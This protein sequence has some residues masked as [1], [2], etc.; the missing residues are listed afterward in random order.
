[1]ERREKKRHKLQKTK[2]NMQMYIYCDK[3]NADEM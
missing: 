1:M 3:A 2:T